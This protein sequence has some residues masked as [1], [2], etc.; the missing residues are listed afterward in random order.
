MA[1]C[2]VHPELIER[3]IIT[4]KLT[5]KSV[6]C[7]RFAF[8]GEFQPIYVDSQS[9]FYKPG[10]VPKPLLLKSRT[11]E[12]WPM[13]IEKAYAKFYGGFKAIDGGQSHNAMADLTGGY[14]ESISLDDSKKEIAD[15]SLW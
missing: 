1:T 9:M 6:Y 13:L 2:A 15:G 12:L 8:N 10:Y 3:L 14:G 4:K 11:K 5:D 7:I